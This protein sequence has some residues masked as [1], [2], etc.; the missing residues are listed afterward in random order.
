VH[1]EEVEC[2]QFQACPGQKHK[3]LSEKITK[4]KRA[5]G[6]AQVMEHL[7]NSCKSLS[8]NPT[9]VKKKVCLFCSVL[10]EVIKMLGLSPVHQRERKKKP[11]K[12]TGPEATL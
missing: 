6:R 9:A 11:H 12:T 8:S 1:E 4:A 3:T 5:W 2:S 10:G 7:P